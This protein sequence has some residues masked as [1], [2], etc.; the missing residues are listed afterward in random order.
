MSEYFVIKR[1][2]CLTCD[3]TGFIPFG[4]PTRGM[5]PCQQCDMGHIETQVDAEAWF[6]EMM[7]RVRYRIF[8]ANG[9]LTS[10]QR[11][12][13]GLELDGLPPTKPTPA[14]ETMDGEQDKNIDLNP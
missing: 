9:H 7:G 14:T 5:K 11:R 8:D 1:E 3:G 13:G 2:K 4:P 12:F 6:L 10:S